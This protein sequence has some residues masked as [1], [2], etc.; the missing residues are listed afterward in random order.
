MH[1]QIPVVQLL[2][3]Y[4]AGLIVQIRKKTDACWSQSLRSWIISENEFNL[5][6]F[7]EA[8]NGVGY[9]DYSGL[10]KEAEANNA[11]GKEVQVKIQMQYPQLI[12]CYLE[13]LQKTRYSPS[14]IKTYVHYFNEFLQAFSPKNPEEI[15]HEEINQYILKLIREKNISS[16]QQNQR[17]NAIKFYFEKV[18]G[19]E[20]AYFEIDWPRKERRLPDVLSK[21]EIGEMLKVTSNQKHKCLIAL[22]YSCGLRRSEAVNLR[23][24][25]I[26][27]K[28]MMI[29][30]RGAKG[31]K[32]RYVQLAK[33]VLQ[34]LRSYYK[35]ERLS[36]WIFE[37]NKS[38]Q[39]SAMSVYNVVKHAA[40]LAGI[41]KRVYPHILR[42]SYTTHHLELG[43]D[44][45]YIQEWL[46]HDNSK[47]TE[48]YTH[49]SKKDFHR[50]NNP[51][52]DIS[53]DDG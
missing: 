26:D 51:I 45:R 15:T 35:E 1:N 28:R 33:S 19:H 38:E 10:K 13:M 11:P 25:D 3:P 27:S 9:I 43:T 37:G 52:D 31:K 22:I 42:H 32:D 47:T 30:I 8:F 21:E 7:F 34:L 18:L 16:A 12:P 4:D 2:F 24:E 6:D 20:K 46:G 44:L 41:K 40:K 23:I 50:F 49:V 29:K 39:Y 14:T 5:H 48:I 53:L 36:V 17:I